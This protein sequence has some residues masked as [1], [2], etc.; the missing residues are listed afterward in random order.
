MRG[1]HV[2]LMQEFGPAAFTVNAGS[3]A[4][5]RI[6]FTRFAPYPP[7]FQFPARNVAVM[8]VKSSLKSLKARHRAC[9][10]VRRKGRVYVINKVD[11]RYKAKQG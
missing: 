5:Q 6:D 10:I 1:G 7:R 8:K 9:R 3:E 2:R 11:P 4:P